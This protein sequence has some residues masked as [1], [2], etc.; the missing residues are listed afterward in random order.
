[1]A[2]AQ[3]S[4]VQTRKKARGLSALDKQR[5]DREAI[6]WFSRLK[7]ARTRIGSGPLERLCWL[8]RFATHTR[9]E[10]SAL[11]VPALAELGAEVWSFAAQGK[12]G[13]MTRDARK[14]VSA[15]ELADLVETV[16]EALRKLCGPNP[17]VAGWHFEPT[18][19]GSLHHAIQARTFRGYYFG[20]FRP[21]FVMAVA[22]LL[23]AEGSRIK[24]CAQC[25]QLFV[26]RK[27]GAYC[28]TACSQKA[29]T[30]RYRNTQGPQWKE[31]R[32]A[33]YLAQ[34]EKRGDVARVLNHIRACTYPAC[35]KLRKLGDSAVAEKVKMRSIRKERSK[36]K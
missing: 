19:F 5:F 34:M 25:S 12:A 6:E 26:R 35:T 27:R 9:E 36:Q 20:D 31:K 8:L 24:N 15:S 33:Y 7:A 17:D 4:V 14:P 10:L 23:T 11:D 28:S 30:A 22:N 2:F 3:M 18:K 29:R 16:S 13:N 32:H 21:V 1:M